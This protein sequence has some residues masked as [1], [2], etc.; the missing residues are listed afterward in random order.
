MIPATA[1]GTLDRYPVRV[2]VTDLQARSALVGVFEDDAAA[3]AAV[4]R[5]RTAGVGEDAIGVARRTASPPPPD[6]PAMSRVFWSGFWWSVAG[7]IAGGLIGLAVAAF[8][9]GIPGTSGAIWIQIASWGMFA[10]VAGAIIGCYL[11]LDTGDR[12]SKKDAH[13]D[14]RATLVRVRLAVG[15]DG[16]TLERVLIDAGARATEHDGATS[17]ASTS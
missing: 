9:L 13:H 5:L 10:H 17:T 4:L 11:A 8:G 6:T 1:R 2:R 16:A 3:R 12:F 7:A 14:R 15:T